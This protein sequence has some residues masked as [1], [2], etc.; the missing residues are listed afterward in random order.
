[1]GA[2]LLAPAPSVPSLLSTLSP[3][4]SLH[5]NHPVRFSAPRRIGQP[6]AFFALQAALWAA[7]SFA[8]AALLVLAGPFEWTAALGISAVNWLPWAVLTPV[9]FWLSSRFPLERGRLLRSVPVHVVAGLACTALCLWI[10]ANAFPLGRPGGGPQ[11][12][13]AFGRG[14]P[15]GFSRGEAPG[16]TRPPLSDAERAKRREEF[17]NRQRN[18]GPDER[19]GRGGFGGPDRG[20]P[21]FGRS[22]PGSPAQPELAFLNELRRDFFGAFGPFALR[23][24]FGLA[25]YLI[26][27]SAAHALG[28]YRRA[29]ARDLQA[30][31]LTAGL[32]RAK[33][34][35]LRLQLQPHFLFNTLNALSTL[36]HRDARAADELIGDLSELLRLSLHTTDNEVPL[37]RELELLDRY[38]AIEQARLGSRLRIVREIEPAATTALVPTFV[39]QPLAENAVRHGLEPRAGEGT[40]TISARATAQSLILSVAD[41][42]VGLATDQATARRGIGL[43]NT[44]A[45]LQALHGAAAKLEMITPPGGGLRVELTLPFK[46]AAQPEKPTSS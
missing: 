21:R 20:F 18:S 13:R 32:N 30:V 2:A 23:G 27:V 35:A 8:F 14:G 4:A 33:L 29:K 31:E 36:V 16:E 46:T 25:I 12:F 38:L 24:N 22:G 3:S 26:V 6:L 1:M 15:G 44:E 40:L 11:G 10:S 28:F 5:Q 34:D 45:R 42:G 7:L 37:A 19:F 39:L 17:L 41:D 9:I 43:A